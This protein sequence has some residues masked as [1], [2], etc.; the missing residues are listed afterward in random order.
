MTQLSTSSVIEFSPLAYPCRLTITS[1]MSSTESVPCA[2]FVNADSILSRMPATYYAAL[3]GSLVSANAEAIT[4]SSTPRRRRLSMKVDI[5]GFA[6]SLSKSAR[7][8]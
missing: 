4:S 2:N 1:V 8:P 5:S 3:T 6:S 7:K